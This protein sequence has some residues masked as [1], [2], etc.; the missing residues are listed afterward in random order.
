LKKQSNF[1]TN[2]VFSK[3]KKVLKHY[4]IITKLFKNL[5]IKNKNKL[6]VKSYYKKLRRYKRVYSFRIINL[7]KLIKKY[8]IQPYVFFAKK[9]RVNPIDFNFFPLY[10]PFYYYKRKKKSKFYRLT[11]LLSCYKQGRI[12]YDY[13]NFPNYNYNYEHRLSYNFKNYYLKTS[14]L[15]N[16]FSFDNYLNFHLTSVICNDLLFKFIRLRFHF[17]LDFVDDMINNS[18]ISTLCSYFNRFFIFLRKMRKCISKLHIL[19][20]SF[21]IKNKSLKINYLDSI[22]N[23]YVSFFSMINYTSSVVLTQSYVYKY[24]INLSNDNVNSKRLMKLFYSYYK[25][26]VKKLN[27]DTLYL[28]DLSLRY[29]FQSIF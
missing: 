27:S 5:Q 10:Y 12:I 25:S 7:L 11:S 28:L 13:K 24:M 17:N 22:R 23:D 14:D 21:S 4:F 3:N 29:V 16:S 20:I 8:K 26:I 15:S 2:F 18:F 19:P 6:Y 9:R 1:I